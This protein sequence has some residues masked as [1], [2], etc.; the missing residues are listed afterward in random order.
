M[1]SYAMF[2]LFEDGFYVEQKNIRSIELYVLLKLNRSNQTNRSYWQAKYYECNKLYIVSYWRKKHR[3][4]PIAKRGETTC[5]GELINYFR[6]MVI[7][8]VFVL[9]NSFNYIQYYL[10]I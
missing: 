10:P 2:R 3:M 5:N 4:P 1:A 9:S 8:T 7:R 6:M